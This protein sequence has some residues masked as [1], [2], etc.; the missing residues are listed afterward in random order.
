MRSIVIV[1]TSCPVLFAKSTA[2]ARIA[3]GPS[4]AGVDQVAEYGTVV[5]APNC[6]HEPVAQSMLASEHSKKSTSV[7]SASGVDAVT[8]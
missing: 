2:T 1:R 6:S 7:T 3:F 5:S 4:N 8:G